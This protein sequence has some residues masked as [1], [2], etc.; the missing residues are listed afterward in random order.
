M[1][2]PNPDIALIYHYDLARALTGEV[3][4]W[5]A[6]PVNVQAG[7][8]GGDLCR[9]AA[10]FGK[11]R[12]LFAMP[13]Q[14]AVPTPPVVVEQPAVDP[15]PDTASTP[16]AESAANIDKL[17]ARIGQIFVAG[18]EQMMRNHW[19]QGV[20][21]L[22]GDN[23]GHTDDD[24]KRILAAVRSVESLAGMGWHEDDGPPPHTA[25]RRTHF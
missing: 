20:R 6:I 12:D 11:R 22:G 2:K 5:Q 25:R 1:V 15:Q 18:H 3:V 17:R 19:P 13:S 9:A 8:E 10:D 24:L 23:R 21:G 14:I 7:R 16:V 4:D